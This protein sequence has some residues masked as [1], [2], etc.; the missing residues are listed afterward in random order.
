M[1]TNPPLLFLRFFRWYCHP[2]LVDHIEGDLIEVYRQRLKKK[3]KRSADI[4]FA[5]DVLL[6]F[7][8]GIIKP[9]EGYKNLDNYGMIKSYFK[10][11]WRNLWKNRASTFINVF[12]LSVGLI[13]CLLI[14]LYVQHEASYDEFQ[15]NGDRIARVI[16]QYSFNGSDESNKGNFTSTKVAPVFARTFPEVESSIRMTDHDEIV[17]RNEDLFTERHFL[18]A[19]STFFKIFSFQFLQ[20]NPQKALDGPHRVV[21]TISTARRYFG[22]ENPLGKTLLIGTKEVPF[23]VTGVIID[24]PPNSQI[25]FD[26]LASFSSLGANQEETYFEANYTTYLLLEDAQSLLPLQRKITPFMKKEIAGSGASINFIL[27]PFDR[28]HLHSEY[29]GFVPNTSITYLYILSAVGLLILAIVCLT[30][31]NLSTAQSMQRAKEVGIRKVVGANKPQ[32]FWQFIGESFL[33]FS[34]A[35]LVSIAGVVFILPYFNVLAGQQFQSQNLFT[36]WFALFAIGI[37]IVV[38][39]LAGSYPAIVLSGFYPVRVLKGVFKNTS[40]GKWVQ[41]SLMVFQFAISVFLIV[42]TVIILR[43]LDFIQHKKLGYDRHHV[44]SLPMNDKVLDKLPVIKQ[45]FKSNPEVI[46]VSR[47]VSSPVQIAGGYNMRSSTMSESEQM[48]VTATPIDEDYIKTT[49]LQIIA[50]TDLIEQDLKDAS[51]GDWGSVKRVYHFIL[52]E[53]AARQLGWSS[54]EAIGKKMFM[55]GR[56]GFV[57][58]VVKDFHFQSIHHVIKP[59]VLFTEVRTH[60]QVLVKVS[61]KD[62]P[63]TILFME[64][65]WKQLVPSVPFEYQFLDDNY[66]QLYRSENQLGI[67]MKLFSG[68]A[69]ILACIGLLGLSAYTIQQRIKEIGIRKILGASPMRIVGLL[70]G[71]F[72]KLVMLSILISCPPGYW[73]MN[74]WLLGFAYRVEIDWWIFALAAF[75]CIG[76]TLLTVSVQG[77]KAALTN[78]VDSLKL[79]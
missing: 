58:A 50:G 60:G 2:K 14:A 10:I 79:E 13:S 74:R 20:G 47:C 57:K 52:N 41:Q 72:V 16:M 31:T 42:S 25:K 17:K 40:S 38:S 26:F 71:N 55:G 67:V 78:P 8:P 22:H 4:K 76:I 43:Q 18:Y 75:S 9:R 73:L 33:L 24:Y 21:L 11:G 32:L 23:E 35:I 48:S 68:I 51:L 37:T 61:G 15:P 34:A 5:I 53:S 54:Q 39:F 7:R 19:D 46:N 12:G 56:Q 27:E 1:K 3:G 70:S 29:A 62:I 64:N 66:E 49:G 65:K 77:I 59:V 45:E 6:L 28:I 69:V 44:L 63:K 36:L 30:Y